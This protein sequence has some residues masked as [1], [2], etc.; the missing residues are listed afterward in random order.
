M[1]ST[2]RL[3]VELPGHLVRVTAAVGDHGP[4]D[5]TPDDHGDDEA[6]DRHP[7]PQ[8]ELRLA[9]G[10]GAPEGSEGRQGAATEAERECAEQQKARD[11][12]SVWR[13]PESPLAED[14]SQIISAAS[15]APAG[16]GCRVPP[17][18]RRP[19]RP[20]SARSD[21][22]GLAATRAGPGPRRR[23]PGRRERWRVRVLAAASGTPEAAGV[24]RRPTQAACRNH[25]SVGAA[26]PGD[27]RSYDA[28]CRRGH[29]R[30]GVG[31]AGWRSRRPRSP[32]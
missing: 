4:E 8:L 24:T 7:R 5:Q 19:P 2:G 12:V 28:A 16:R 10:R 31:A 1:I 21:D 13:P 30:D 9:L 22:P 18:S 25:G 27:R 17:S 6:G 29:R 14:S 20:R 32:S 15:Q 11:A 23:R 3:L 26:D